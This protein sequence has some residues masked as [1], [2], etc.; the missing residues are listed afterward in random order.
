MS[1]SLYPDQ[2]PHFDGPD[3]SRNCLQRLSADDTSRQRV[4]AMV[5]LRLTN[6]ALAHYGRTFKTDFLISNLVK[7]PYFDIA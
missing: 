3:L 1:N 5:E 4:N 6:G 2:N 7:F